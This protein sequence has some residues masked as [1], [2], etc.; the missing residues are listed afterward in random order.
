MTQSPDDATPSRLVL[1][2]DHQ[3][4]L[5]TVSDMLAP[6]FTIIG[7]AHDG[8]TLLEAVTCLNPDL[9]VLDL[10]MPVYDGLQVARRLKERGC[11]A[12]LVF[13]TVHDDEDFAHEALQ[14]GALGYVVKASMAADLPHAIREAMEGRTFVSPSIVMTNRPLPSM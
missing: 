8:G 5:D 13:L 10:S 2:D 4:I 9:V 7:T 1:A 3:T 11:C 6:D 14:T 12:K